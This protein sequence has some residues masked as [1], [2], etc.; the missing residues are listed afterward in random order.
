MLF[1]SHAFI[2]IF[3][4][5]TLFGFFYC[6]YY[7]SRLAIGWLVAASVF[8]YGWWNPNSIIILVGSIAVNFAVGRT[9]AGSQPPYHKRFRQAVLFIGIVV[10]LSLLLYYK[11]FNFIL[12]TITGFTGISTPHWDITLPLGISFFTFTQIAFLVDAYRG[13]VK[14]YNPL[15]YALFVTFFPHLI[16]GPILH[17]KE[18]MPQ[19]SKADIF[20]A[21]TDHLSVGLTVFLIGLFKKVIIADGIGRYVSPVFT[22]AE[23]GQVLTF[24]EAWA[25]A[26]A[27]TFQLYFDFSGYS[28]MAIG[29]ARVFGIN[30]PL[31]FN[32][33]YKAVSIIDFWRRWHMTLTR[34]LK[35]YL[36]IP[37]GGNR[38]G[39]CRHFLNL[40]I[41]MLICGLWH[42]AGVTFIVWGALHGVYLIINHLWR[43]MIQACGMTNFSSNFCRMFAARLLTFIAVVIGWVVFRAE[44]LPAA[45]QLLKAMAGYNGV[46][47]SN[48]WL[49]RLGPV[50]SWMQAI[51]IEFG[52]LTVPL[53]L[54]AW[55]W[56]IP[57]LAIVWFMPNTQ[58]YMASYHIGLEKPGIAAPRFPALIWRP[59]WILAVAFGIAG[60][61]TILSLHH[62]SE[63]LYFQF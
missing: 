36:Y 28:D 7:K 17:H 25:G 50:A 39:V 61:Y 57:L 1:N 2:F 12:S 21:N 37:L 45:I 51:G 6:G 33:P 29:L 5:I 27:Y 48:A 31:N 34:F 11:Y 60:C 53:A 13:E 24:L 20:H 18:M 19:F 62:E 52:T 32:S 55:A 43:R 47:M 10:N 54:K 9:L 42:G 46:V 44:T 15:H 26:L 38:S 22:A 3:L 8:F 63:F 40:F 58:E 41:T 59:S 23:S 49:L 35:D 16:A 56:V 14:E 4:P 30:L